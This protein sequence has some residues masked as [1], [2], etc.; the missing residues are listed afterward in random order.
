MQKTPFAG[1]TRLNPNESLSTDGFSF[2]DQ[3]IALIDYF[4]ELALTH[5]HDGAPALADP[6]GAPSATV[7]TSG[8]A[9]PADI[10]LH[11]GYTLVDAKGGETLLSDTDLVSTEPPFDAPASAPT[12][13]V[14]YGIGN[15]LIGSYYYGLTLLDAGG[16]ESEMSPWTQVDRLPGDANARVNLSD[17]TTDFAETGAVAWRLYRSKPGSH[18]DLLAEGT[19]DTYTDDGSVPVDCDVHPPSNT[20]NTTNS[21]NK[22]TVVVPLGSAGVTPGAE[23]F[24]LYASLDGSFVS[25]CLVGNFDTALAGT[26]IEILSLGFLRGSPPDV[27]TSKGGLPKID[28]TEIEN[29][30]DDLGGGLT[31]YGWNGDTANPQQVVVE[32]VEFLH[33]IDG[34]A[35]GAP[36]FIV[37]D[38]G[39]GSAGVQTPFHHRG[40]ETYIWRA[41]PGEIEVTASAGSAGAVSVGP[42]FTISVDDIFGVGSSLLDGGWIYQDDT[43]GSPATGDVQLDAATFEAATEVHIAETDSNAID[44]TPQLDNLDI[45]DRII[46][47]D[48]GTIGRWGWFEISGAVVDEG[49]WRRIPVTFVKA[50]P[51]GGMPVDASQAYVFGTRGYPAPGYPFVIRARFDARHE[52]GLGGTGQVALMIDG[53]IVQGFEVSELFQSEVSQADP[54]IYYIGPDAIYGGDLTTQDT[55]QLGPGCTVDLVVDPFQGGGRIIDLVAWSDDGSSIFISN[56]MMA[57]TPLV[58]A[59]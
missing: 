9:I 12:A 23:S 3:N 57:V 42:G 18:F 30:P 11:I 7:D 32:G 45:G 10:T 28:W 27:S 22:V 21:T 44:Q 1:L 34:N 14:E 49:T 33:L 29:I 59:P 40:A 38:E 26:D 8:G 54:F 52:D 47:G 46:V 56:Q 19:L 13:E 51:A 58:H 36:E 16:G 53:E 4:I 50:G 55:L 43:G 2:Q 5:R 25:P 15:I 41:E 48:I 6:F 39:G 24:N 17:L 35:F 20:S 31:V 37:T